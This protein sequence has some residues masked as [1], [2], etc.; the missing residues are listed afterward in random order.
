MNGLCQDMKRIVRQAINLLLSA[1]FA[2]SSIAVASAA[3]CSTVNPVAQNDG[4]MMACCMQHKTTGMNNTCHCSVKQAPSSAPPTISTMS[5]VDHYIP[6]AEMPQ[7]KPFIGFQ[8]EPLNSQ[9]LAL[10]C[11][12]RAP[13]PRLYIINCAFL[14]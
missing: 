6:V 9:W 12:L 11:R 7:P 8:K 4:T 2:L 5:A 14:S 10:D 3:P 13:P 1:A